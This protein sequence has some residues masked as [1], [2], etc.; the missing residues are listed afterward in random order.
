[1]R[2]LARVASAAQ[3][4]R[5][6]LDSRCILRVRRSLRVV[7]PLRPDAMAAVTAATAAAAGHD[8]TRP[9][10]VQGSGF[11]VEAADTFVSLKNM[12]A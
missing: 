12:N 4:S 3:L 8:G 2:Q 5:A 1:M 9:H 11:L 6:E 10:Y 7:S